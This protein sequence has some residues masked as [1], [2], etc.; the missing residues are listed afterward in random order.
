MRLNLQDKYEALRFRLMVVEALKMVK[1]FYS[2]RELSRITGLSETVLCRY[3]RGNIIPSIDQAEK[4]WRKLEELMDLR[5]V[6]SDAIITTDKGFIDT[7]PV[8]SNPLIM[9]MAAYHVFTR[10]AGRRVTRILTPATNGIPLATSI[11]LMLEAPLV[12]AKKSKENPEEEYYEETVVEGPMITTTFYVPRRQLR[13]HDSILIVDDFIQTGKTVRALINLTR[14][15]KAIVSGAVFLLGIEGE[16]V[17][18]I[19]VPMLVFLM[20]PS[21]KSMGLES[22]RWIY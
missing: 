19:E 15:A 13:R 14:K 12:V 10:F 20:L 16:W 8:L 5:K 3:V 9:K 18:E 11:S 4:L 22:P 6:V 1:Q 2:Y 21:H 17:K 7:S